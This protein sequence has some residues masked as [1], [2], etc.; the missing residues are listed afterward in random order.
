MENKNQPINQNQDNNNQAEN[1]ASSSNTNTIISEELKKDFREKLLE[2]YLKFSRAYYNNE[3]TIAQYLIDQKIFYEKGL[4]YFSIEELK[5]IKREAK[6]EEGYLDTSDEEFD[7]DSSEEEESDNE[8]AEASTSGS[9]ENREQEQQ[10]SSEK[11]KP[12][13]V[14]KLSKL[15]E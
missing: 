8:E 2:V 14:E 10:E 15:I 11:I 1:S 3:I 13:P 12:D 6:K 9:T 7:Y 4:K 5:E